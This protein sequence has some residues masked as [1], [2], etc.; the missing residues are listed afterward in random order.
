MKS[1]LRLLGTI[2]VPRNTGDRI[3]MMPFDLADPKT[4]PPAWREFVDEMVYLGP[5]R[6]GVGYLTVDDAMVKRGET[7]RRPGLH[8]DGVGG[9]G[10]PP[11]PWGGA[12]GMLVA[13][14]RV[15]SRAWHQFIDGEPAADGDC[16]HL[17]P[18][19][20]DH[21][22]QTLWCDC[23][24]WLGPNCVHEAVEMAEDTQRTFVRISMPSNAP[25][26]D[27]Y[28]PSP[29]GVM[30]TGPILPARTAQMGFRQ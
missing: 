18:R 11:G 9:W 10:G 30:P 8:V 1:E 19:L 16:E 25:W 26:F 23:A 22:K 14:S 15:G 24:W 17:R 4:T 21:A 27:G 13:A 28:T 20:A 5:C 3:M 6:S 7:H 12:Q 2:G 29:Y